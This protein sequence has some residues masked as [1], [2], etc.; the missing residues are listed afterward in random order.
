MSWD[1]L[2][3]EEAEL[4]SGIAADQSAMAKKQARLAKLRDYMSAFRSF[5]F[6]EEQDQ[7][8]RYL[9]EPGGPA[10]SQWKT[11]G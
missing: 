9:F 5:H 2:L 7:P 1:A 10:P 6:G 3:R 4:N 11:W 8:G